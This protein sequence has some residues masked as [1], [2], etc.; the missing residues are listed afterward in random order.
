ML[1][2]VYA[3][4]FPSVCLCTKED[5]GNCHNYMWHGANLMGRC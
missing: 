2:W 3:M 4:A 5:Q 1:V